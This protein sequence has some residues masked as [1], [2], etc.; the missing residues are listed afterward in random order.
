LQAVLDGYREKLSAAWKE[1]NAAR[2]AFVEK[3]NGLDSARLVIGKLNQ[4]NSIEEIDELVRILRGCIDFISLLVLCS[5]FQSGILS[6]NYLDDLD[7]EE[8]E[9]YGT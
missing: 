3:R 5:G 9:D 1:E 4:A 7:C 8:R 2:A 6:T